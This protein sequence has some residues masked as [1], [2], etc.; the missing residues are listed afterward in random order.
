MKSAFNIL[1]VGGNGFVGSTLARG[2]APYYSV[3][4]TYQNEFTPI[5][6]V[7]YLFNKTLND[8]DECQKIINRV[9][10][11]VVIYCAGNHDLLYCEK[12]S[13][14]AQT[15]HSNGVGNVMATSELIKAKF[16]YVSSDFVFSG[17]DGNFT[18]S[19]TAIPSYQLGKLKLG[20]ETFVRSRASN[21]TII[22]CAPLI[23]R[24][25][26]DHPSWIDHLRE[27][28]MRG[29][30]VKF[31]QNSLH[32][33]V[34]IKSLIKVIQKVIE[35]DIKNKTLHWGGLNKISFYELAKIFAERYE[36]NSNKIEATD[37]DALSMPSDYSLNFTQTLKILQMDPV[38]L[39]QSLD[40]LKE[41]V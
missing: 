36:L 31:E 30:S 10:P 41:S 39:E 25:P 6:S 2:L 35:N 23:G 13:K 8:K 27:N 4:C 20:G 9:E 19:D 38:T 21:H 14:I 16:I 11:R 40:L 26:I 22:R 29:K 37:P 12:N 15:A 33:P 32:N 28:L 7:T 18:E 3:F 17:V 1:I 34:H 5:D 24:G